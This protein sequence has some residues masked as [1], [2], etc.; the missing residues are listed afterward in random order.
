MTDT[1]EA[2][3]EAAPQQEPPEKKLNW[4]QRHYTFTGTVF[5]MVFLWLSLTPS[6]LPRGPLFQGLVSG[7]AGAFGYAI[8]VLAVWLVRY[9]RSKDASPHAP[10][11][12]WLAVVVV[13]VIGQI[14]MIIYFHVWQ[15]EVRDLNGVPRLAFWDHPLT[16]VL[17]IV[18]LFIFVEIGQL[19]GKLVRFL[20]RQLN[21]FAPPRV[22]AVVVVV[23]LLALSIALLNGVV[24]RVGNGLPQQDVRRGQR[25]DR[26]RLPR[27]GVKAAVGRAGVVGQLGVAGPPGPGVRFG[28]PDGRRTLE[29]QRQAGDRA[30]QGLRGFA[31][32]RRHQGHR[33]AGRPGTPAHRRPGPR[34]GRR[35]DHHRY[36]LDQ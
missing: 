11:W 25:R 9:M 20:I 5:A 31:F 26:P 12:A 33:G 14:L 30:D 27:A 6:L 35:R 16:A 24:V 22:S 3:E 29:V 18:V 8:G 21:R 28:R 4:W 15:D 13:G 17:S 32:R 19:I 23:L 10:G 36:G 1:A 2:T 7:A 34:R